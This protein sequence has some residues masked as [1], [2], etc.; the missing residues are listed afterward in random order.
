MP[1]APNVGPPAVAPSARNKKQNNNSNE[2]QNR[3]RVHDRETFRDFQRLLETLTD[4]GCNLQEQL[5]QSKILKQ[6]VEKT[7]Q[8]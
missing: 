2:T 5:S 4:K 1:S 7:N 6:I 8:T 3:F